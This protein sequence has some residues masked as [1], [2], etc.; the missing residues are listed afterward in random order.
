MYYMCLF[1]CIVQI[2]IVIRTDPNIQMLST[3]E[4]QEAQEKWCKLIIE[5]SFL[6][7]IIDVKIELQIKQKAMQSYCHFIRAKCSIDFR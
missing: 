4:T 2:Y 6:K 3:S 7:R 5:A 1:V